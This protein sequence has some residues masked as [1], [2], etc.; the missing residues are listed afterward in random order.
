MINLNREV[1]GDAVYIGRPSVWG[2][3]YR[4]GPDGDRGAVVAKYRQHVLGRVDLLR[5]VPDLVGVDLACW[6]KPRACHGDVLLELVAQY[7]AAKAAGKPWPE[8]VT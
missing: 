7:E 6:C 3:P 4:V 2:N 5:R 8:A 1:Q